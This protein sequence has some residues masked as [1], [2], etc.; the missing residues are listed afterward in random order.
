M[1]ADATDVFDTDL[2][3]VR[4]EFP[5]PVRVGC[6][7][8]GAFA[9]V[10]PAWELGRALWP[11]NVLA[12][13]FAI[14]IGGAGY[15]GMQFI[16]A[17]LSGWGDVWTYPRDEIHVQRREWGRHTTT[18]LSTANVAA[19]EVRRSEDADHDDAPWQVVIVPKPT[20]SGL[21][22]IAGAGGVFDAGRYGT[23]AYA[24]R[25]RNALVAHLGL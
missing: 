20:V 16:R 24:E 25:V 15:V 5:W 19:V 4:R 8:A 17:G 13:F 21:A 3:L 9:V 12:P 7:V 6:V 23:Q 2:P 11:P 1:P 22:A 14:I 10:M 18:R